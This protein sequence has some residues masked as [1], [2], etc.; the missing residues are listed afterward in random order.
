[1][2]LVIHFVIVLEKK[3]KHYLLTATIGH[4][5]VQTIQTKMPICVSYFTNTM[6]I[7]GGGVWPASFLPMPME[8]T[9]CQPGNIYADILTSANANVA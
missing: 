6:P 9:G 4:I 7:F 2:H 3:Y 1:M 5:I 8:N